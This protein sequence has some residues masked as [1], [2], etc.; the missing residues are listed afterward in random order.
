MAIDA[1]LGGGNCRVCGLVYRRVTIAAIHF[2]VAD[3]DFVTKRNR[4]FR[5]VAHIGCTRRSAIRENY[6]GVDCP[7]NGQYCHKR[8]ESVHPI[9]EMESRW[10]GHCPG[11]L[12]GAARQTV[13]FRTP[14]CEH[15]LH[16]YIRL[17]NPINRRD[18]W[19]HHLPNKPQRIAISYCDKLSHGRLGHIHQRAFPLRSMHWNDVDKLRSTFLQFALQRTP[20]DVKNFGGMG[21]VATAVC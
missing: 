9:G 15:F 18:K 6:R 7:S 2:Q 8:N 3:M 5:R 20:G 16:R 1:C 21:H 12:K 4:L 10:I 14:V 11:K 13:Q 19:S 17:Q